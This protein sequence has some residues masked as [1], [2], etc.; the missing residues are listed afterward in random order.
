VIAA[1]DGAMILHLG[2]TYQDAASG[3]VPFR[4]AAS[5]E[6]FGHLLTAAEHLT[7]SAG[8]RALLVRVPGS[9]FATIDALA[10]RGYRAGRVMVRM[11]AGQN[12][13]YDGG[14]GYYIDNW[15]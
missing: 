4:A 13:D 14:P 10:V 12:L 2:P 11:K 8:R 5:R 3:F 9:N 7:A 15:L 6:T 1:A